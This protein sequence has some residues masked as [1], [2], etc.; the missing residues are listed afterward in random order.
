MSN[1]FSPGELIGLLRAER[2]GRA[3]EEAICYQAVLLGITRASMNTQSF[4]SEASFQET[5]RVLAK[6]ALLGHI[7]RLKG[8]KENVVLGG[9][10]PVDSGFKTPSSEPNNIPNNIAFALKKK[11]IY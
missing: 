11:R 5:A 3:L 7:D 4:T 8:L 2:M 1:V 10:I 9:M 6:A